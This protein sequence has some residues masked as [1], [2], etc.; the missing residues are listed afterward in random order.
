MTEL[1]ATP[2]RTSWLSSDVEV[3]NAATATYVARELYCSNY[4]HKKREFA[5]ALCDRRYILSARHGLLDPLESIAPYDESVRDFNVRERN[6]WA[7]RVADELTDEIS[8]DIA[9]FL[10]GR[11]YVEP[12]SDRLIEEFDGS[13]IDRL[14]HPFFETAGIGEQLE[15][16]A[17]ALN[18][19]DPLL[20]V[21]NLANPALY[22]IDGTTDYRPSGPDVNG[23]RLHVIKYDCPEWIAPNET[24]KVKVVRQGD[25]HFARGEPI[26][27]G[28]YE[29][30]DSIE[31][32]VEW[33]RDHPAPGDDMSDDEQETEPGQADL[34]AFATDG[35]D[36][37]LTPEIDRSDSE[38]EQYGA[39]SV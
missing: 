29:R 32:A 14:Y 10:A 26:K 21:V 33:M 36:R 6:Q 25:P 38:S 24:E 22:E 27:H 35:G 16:L 31:R 20:S 2:A 37:S 39:D 9:V 5:E 7:F 3:R 17:N 13:D 15:W 11:D 30:A 1:S 28:S 8:D 4:F 34:S 12:V 23:W 19:E 18:A